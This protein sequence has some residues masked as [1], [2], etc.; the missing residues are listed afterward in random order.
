MLGVI[1][2]LLII[3][4]MVLNTIF[5]VREIRRNEQHDSFINAVTHELKTPGRLDP[6]L[7]RDA[8][9]ARA[10]RGQAARVLPD[11]AGGQRPAA[12]HDR[13]GA[14]RRQ[15]RLV[16]AARAQ[17]ADA[18]QPGELVRE[19]VELARTRFRL[20]AES[21]VYEHG[22]RWPSMVSGDPEELKTAVWNL[23]DNAIKYSPTGHAGPGAARGTP[24]SGS[25]CACSTTASAFPRRS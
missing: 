24:S 12:A 3:A 25:P 8:P 23:I 10:R 15:R 7:S 1:F 22:R 4:G 5:L 9:D 20:D 6:A 14:A 21:L 11:H 2:F 18:D 17:R 13:A 16:A 19:C